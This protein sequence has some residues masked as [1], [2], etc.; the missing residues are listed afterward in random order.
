MKL[1][2]KGIYTW[3]RWKV[4]RQM[5]ISP[6][7]RHTCSWWWGWAIFVS[8]VRHFLVLRVSLDSSDRGSHQDVNEGVKTTETWVQE[9]L[10]CVLLSDSELRSSDNFNSCP[11][12]FVLWCPLQSFLLSEIFNWRMEFPASRRGAW[13][14]SGLASKA[15][16]SLMHQPT[17]P[18]SFGK[19][20]LLLNPTNLGR[21]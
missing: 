17:W 6:W 15:V 1:T 7:V 11:T 13:D 4:Q 12:A 14:L 10:P 3:E 16:L 2:L 21:F 8:R 9:L 5:A 19:T 20:I 18:D